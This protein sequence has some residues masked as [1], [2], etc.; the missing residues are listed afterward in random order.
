[1]G[2]RQADCT[3]QAG[4]GDVA[5]LVAE[6]SGM[7]FAP[8][9]R[10]EVEAGIA[11]A[12][13]HA[14][15]DDCA[16]YLILVG[17]NGAALDHLVDELRI[18]ETHFMRHPEQLE[19]IRRDVLP[20]LRRRGSSTP[21]RVWSAGCASGEE[22]YTLAILLEQ[23]GLDRGAFVLGTDLSP[24]AL[25]KARA[26]S[27]SDWSMRG[28]TAQYLQDYFHHIRNRRIVVD[29][30]RT[31]VRFETLNL[32]GPE[33]YAAAGAS[34]MDLIHCRNVLIY[35]DRVTAGAI[36]A[37]LYDCLAEGGMLMTAGADPL[38]GQYAPFDVDVTR[39]GLVYRRPRPARPGSVAA[40][41]VLAALP[42]PVV[43]EEPRKIAGRE[44][45][46][47]AEAA[48][49]LPPESA[50][51]A[52]EQVMV[53]A[54]GMGA[55]EA[56][57]MAQAALRRHPL[58]APLHYLRAALLLTLDRDGEAEREAQRSLYLE[59]SLAVAHFLL[60]TI[61]RKRG[62]RP[63]ALR[64]FRNVRDLC[65]ARPADEEVPAGAGERVGALHFAASAEMRRLEVTVG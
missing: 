37:R 49:P 10:V 64:A 39:A 51:Q 18:G 26:A 4:Y 14:G 35:F 5:A 46:A 32:V 36:A 28:V 24:A 12:M 62:A 38:I 55:F 29:R 53:L 54:N 15:V 2:K 45:P 27:Y 6:R 34:R 48:S 58:D 21:P 43:F 57:V 13:R 44:P 17:S 33:D 11:R 61:L 65:A 30:I 8:N 1:M 56:E 19:L 52:F 16:A 50:R 47:P 20:A 42:A 25:Q 41:R 59:P 31:R 63:G 40:K 60:G 9:R 7:V 3:D 23:E 22:A